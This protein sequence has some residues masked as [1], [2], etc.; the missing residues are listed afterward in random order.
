[1]HLSPGCCTTMG[2]L[3]LLPTWDA[4]EQWPRLHL[5]PRSHVEAAWVR[6]WMQAMLTQVGR[7]PGIGLMLQAWLHCCTP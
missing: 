1:M 5:T 2:K 7:W 3:S 6:C 4:G